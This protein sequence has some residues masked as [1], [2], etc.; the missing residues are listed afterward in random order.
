VAAENIVAKKRFLGY[1][2]FKGCSKKC[3]KNMERFGS[4]FWLSEVSILFLG[5]SFCGNLNITFS[6]NVILGIRVKS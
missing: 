4:H 5:G 1:L 2:R 3:F 6:Y